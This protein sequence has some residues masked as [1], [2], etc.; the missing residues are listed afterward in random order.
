[1]K[2]YRRYIIYN[3][4]GL[5][6]FITGTLP[7]Y[8]QQD[9]IYNQY[10]FN[11]LVINPA[12]AGSRD[13]LSL[14]L[15]SRQQWV[16]FEGAPKTQTFTAHTPVTL[17]HIGLGL[18]FVKDE[19]GPVSQTAFFADYSY[20]FLVTENTSLSLGLKGGFNHFVVDFSKLDQTITSEDPAYSQSKYNKMLPNFGFGAY[21]TNH[22]YYFGL[23][24]PR[25]MQNDL[26]KSTNDEGSVN[27][28]EVR[29]YFI[30]GGGIFNLSQYFKLKPSFMGRFS[31]ASPAS[32]DINLNTLYNEKLWFGV[33]YRLNS[34]FGGVLQYQFTP[35][36]KIGYAYEMNINDLQKIN[37]GT[38]EIM[39]SF[40]FNFKKGQVYNPRYF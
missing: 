34:A 31:E 22:H 30:M 1:M 20:K 38:H 5:A 25:I 23:S 14:M 9:P 32:V 8:G 19:I 11:T 12:Y 2:F 16:G 33:M 7:G 35:Q 39:V 3:I 37:D 36:L 18:S 10:Q 17:K 28:K 40:E 24:V 21:L 6:L 4:I 27:S 15:L 29:H 13:M 26:S